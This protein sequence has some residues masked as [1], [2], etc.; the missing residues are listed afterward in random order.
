MNGI[1]GAAGLL[2]DMRLDAEQRDYVRVIRE[3]SDHLASL[4]QDILDFS[5]LDGGRLEAE[6]GRLRSA[7][8]G[9]GP[10]QCWTARRARRV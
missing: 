2:Q 3:S 6:I 8:F 10:S 7:R 9:P 1:I 5:R 4:L